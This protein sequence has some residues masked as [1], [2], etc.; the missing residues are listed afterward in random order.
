MA[1]TNN[2]A[3]RKFRLLLSLSSSRLSQS[4][5]FLR[6]LHCLTLLL[7][8]YDDFQVEIFDRYGNSE[9]I[10]FSQD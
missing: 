3:A 9:S 1:L 8:P 7:L 6:L 10:A 4:K 5:I 2:L